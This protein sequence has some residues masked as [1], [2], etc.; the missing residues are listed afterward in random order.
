MSYDRRE[1]I[2]ERLEAILGGLTIPLL[3]DPN[4]DTPAQIAPGNFVRNRNELTKDKVPGVILL[5]ADEVRDARATL[6]PR[7][8]QERQVPVSIMKMTP[9][10]YVVLDNRSITNVNVGQDLSTARMV[11]L[12]AILLDNTL[13]GIVGA[14]G[15]IALNSVVTD[16]ARNRTMKGQMGIAI[17]FRYPLL[18]KDVA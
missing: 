16:L 17:D 11:I 3:G 2:L 5:D 15:D 18:P 9:E 4:G 1:L 14:N 10:I 7:G 12:K 8:Q 6:P 13:Q